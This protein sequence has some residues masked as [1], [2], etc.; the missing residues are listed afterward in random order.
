MHPRDLARR[1]ESRQV[2]ELDPPLQATKDSHGKGFPTVYP[3]G[4]RIRLTSQ[5][6]KRAGEACLDRSM[7]RWERTTYYLAARKRRPLVRSVRADNARRRTITPI[8]SGSHISPSLSDTPAFSF[9]D[10]ALL[11]LHGHGR[12]TFIYRYLRDETE[13]VSSRAVA[14]YRR[15]NRA[16]DNNS[17]RR[18]S[19]SHALDFSFALSLCLG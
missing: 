7:H 19:L 1:S 4:S 18:E 6:R 5:I 16:A 9:V 13:Q 2:E 14:R 15:L 12:R 10:S 11:S 8:K 3:Y 17:A